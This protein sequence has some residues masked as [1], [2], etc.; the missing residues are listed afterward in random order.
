MS[1]RGRFSNPLDLARLLVIDGC[2]ASALPVLK[3]LRPGAETMTLNIDKEF[4]ALIPPLTEE[5]RSALEL[6]LLTDG[7]RDALVVWNGTLIDGHNRYA[8]CQQHGIPFQIV[9]L[10]FPDR[11]AVI[12]WMIQ[13]QLGR[14]NITDYTRGR[15]ALRLKD[16]IA[17]QA[18]ARQVANLRQGNESPVMQNFAQRGATRDEL[19]KVADL[20]GE[21]IRKVETIERAAPDAVK[22]AA[23]REE[24]SIH[25]AY[26]LTKALETVKAAN[27][28]FYEETVDRGHITNLDGEDVPLT[29][30]DPT[31]IRVIASEDEYERVK[32]QEQYVADKLA[33]KERRTQEEL[34]RRTQAAQ[35]PLPTGK[36]RAIV[37]D[38][39]YPVQK[40][41]R[42]ARPNQG[43][44]LDYPT[45]SMEDIYALPV[46]ELAADEG[47][48]LYLW[49]TQKYL[50]NAL[51]M[52]Q[53]WGFHYQCLMTWVKPTGMTPYSWMYN[54]ELVVFA[55]RGDLPLLRNGLKLS[56][57]A[58]SSG[59]SIKPDVFFDRV[60]QA[61]PEPRLEMFARRTRE[62][63]SAWGNEVP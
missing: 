60:L 7:C 43:A 41:E 3:E 24:I 19:A 32:R 57:E 49:T 39:P 61:S 47:C 36:Y 52:V 6:S 28:K 21:T 51:A 8:I 33:E 48:H 53:A 45:M 14:R 62:G 46:N 5:E 59:H 30:A 13:N 12:V 25:K 55:R 35:T 10:D 2:S 29:E 44:Y 40:I 1:T 11:N 18:K 26:E 23:E 50:P 27:P 31:L 17:T 9:E 38:P 54:T 22:Q 34:S 42:D 63:F 56:F 37:I 16:A 4:Q 20:S 15:L 58:P